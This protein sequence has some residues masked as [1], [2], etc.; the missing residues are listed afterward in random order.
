MQLLKNLIVVRL[1]SKCITSK[2]FKNMKRKINLMFFAIAFIAIQSSC[3]HP[4]NHK[5]RGNGNIISETRILDETFDEVELEDNFVVYVVY[6]SVSEIEIETDENLIQ[7]IKT[8]VKNGK[9]SIRTVLGRNINPS[10]DVIVYV[11]SPFISDLT[12]SGSGSMYADSLKSNNSEITLSGS[13]NIQVKVIA[14]FVDVNIEGSGNINLETYTNSINATISGSGDMFLEGNANQSEFEIDGSGC[15]KAYNLT[16]NDCFSTI[17]GSGNIYTKVS[18]MLDV[19]IT[20]SG[21][22]YYIGFPSIN[23]SITGSGQIIN[24]N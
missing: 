2:N 10:Q 23:V 20:G 24:N 12:L 9:L 22:V 3:L 16:Q 19:K 17:S 4:F 11:R 1:Y 14:N 21:D 8:E 13:G 5:V 6:D 18:D 15:I 7:Y